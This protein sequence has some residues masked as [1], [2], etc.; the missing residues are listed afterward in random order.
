MQWLLVFL[1][2]ILQKIFQYFI[3]RYL[4]RTAVFLA[5]ASFSIGL[6]I[7]FLAFVKIS[8]SALEV[9]APEGVSI[10]IGFFP[11]IVF[12]FATLYLTILIAKRVYDWKQSLGKSYYQTK[13]MLY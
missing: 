4:Y 11:G 9:S 1:F 8:V 12:D 10:A 5:W 6:Y 13:G 7:A 3:K 2:E